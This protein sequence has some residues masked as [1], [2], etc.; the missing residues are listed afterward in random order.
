MTVTWSFG[1]CVG[2]NVKLIGMR[3]CVASADDEG[4]R[5]ITGAIVSAMAVAARVE[6]A[7]IR[8]LFIFHSSF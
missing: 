7:T 4:T 3:I 1:H 5:A 6:R 2:V 8:F